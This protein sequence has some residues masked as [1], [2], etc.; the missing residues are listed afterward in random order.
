MLMFLGKQ[1]NDISLFTPISTDGSGNELFLVDVL[2]NPS[3]LH[4][5]KYEKEGDKQEVLEALTCL[6][7]SELKVILLRFGFADNIQRKQ[8]EVTRLLGY[9]QGNVSQLEKKAL[10]KLRNKL[11]EIYKY[12]PNNKKVCS[13]STADKMTS[14]S[15]LDDVIANLKNLASNDSIL[16]KK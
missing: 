1:T 15:T 6:N 7:A 12:I 10:R 8:I 5:E 2:D 3:A 11:F 4:E 13:K 9:S 14:A 16:V